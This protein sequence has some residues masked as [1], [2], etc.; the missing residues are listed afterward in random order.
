MKTG[1]LMSEIVLTTNGKLSRDTLKG[2]ASMLREKFS[3][4]NVR[5]ETDSTMIGGICVKYGGKIYSMSIAD[6]L[7]RLKTYVMNS[8]AKK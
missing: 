4:E 6:N 1:D 5:F 8:E 7:S 3:C 2:I